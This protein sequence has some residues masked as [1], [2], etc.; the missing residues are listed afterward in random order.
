MNEL[1]DVTPNDDEPMEEKRFEFKAQ[2]KPPVKKSIFDR[3]ADKLRT[4]PDIAQQRENQRAIK[5]KADAE[6]AEIDMQIAKREADEATRIREADPAYKAQKKESERLLKLRYAEA[7]RAAA[8]IWLADDLIRR[9]P[10]RLDQQ[11]I[12]WCDSQ[13]RNFHLFGLL[14]RPEKE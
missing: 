8:V 3:I 13:L 4:D 11:L 6:I 10:E 7:R 2:D 5:Q 1:P 12:S 9:H 14:S